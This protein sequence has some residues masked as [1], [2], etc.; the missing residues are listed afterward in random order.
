MLCTHDWLPLRRA[1]AASPAVFAMLWRL[2]AL[3]QAGGQA[4]SGLQG[5]HVGAPS[6]RGWCIHS[7]SVSSSSSSAQTIG[8]S[9][10]QPMYK[11]SLLPGASVV[12]DRARLAPDCLVPRRKGAYHR[13]YT[14]LER[15]GRHTPQHFN[16]L[17]LMQAFNRPQGH[18]L[19]EIPML[20]AFDAGR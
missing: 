4:A 17:W 6:R 20:P 8:K 3:C 18:L 1:P 12:K 9:H 10:S 2:Q 13:T 5:A 16:V 19:C 7:S 15:R 11:R 14:F